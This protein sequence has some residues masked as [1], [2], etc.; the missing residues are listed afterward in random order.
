[1]EKSV[2][3]TNLFYSVKEVFHYNLINTINSKEWYFSILIALNKIAF[4]K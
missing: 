4:F 1:M 3:K 2:D